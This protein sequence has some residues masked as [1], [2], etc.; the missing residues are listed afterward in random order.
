MTL[1]AAGQ[2]ERIRPA[3]Q[4]LA[5]ESVASPQRLPDGPDA[6]VARVIA[7]HLRLLD[8]LL[9]LAVGLLVCLI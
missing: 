5:D 1:D 7:P 9:Q 6:R 4:A 8:R 3:E 2:Q